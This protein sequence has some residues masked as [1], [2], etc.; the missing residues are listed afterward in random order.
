MNVDTFCSGK[1]DILRHF[2]VFCVYEV[3]IIQIYVPKK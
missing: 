1:R 3:I 2:L